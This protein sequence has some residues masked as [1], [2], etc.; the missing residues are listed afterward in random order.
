MFTVCH[1][2]ISL[3]RETTGPNENIEGKLNSDDPYIK[4]GVDRSVDHY[5]AF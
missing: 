1:R 4:I 5:S 3:T 2:V